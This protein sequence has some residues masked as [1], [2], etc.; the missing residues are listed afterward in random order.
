MKRIAF[1]FALTLLSG[2]PALAASVGGQ[3]PADTAI[4]HPRGY[5]ALNHSILIQ[6]GVI[7][8][9]DLFQGTGEYAE[10][11]V[12]YAPRPGS[13]AVFDARW[14]KRVAAAFKLN[15]QPGSAA[16]R[17][18]VER[19]SQV[20][21][22]SEIEALLF[23]RLVAEGGDASSRA[24]LANRS[25][26]LHLPV[27]EDYLLGVDQINLDASTGRF[28][29]VLAWGNAKDERRRVSGRLERMTEVPVLAKRKMG[30]DTIEEGDL[31]W[32]EMPQARLARNAV[33]DPSHLIGMAAK[34]TISAGNPITE[35]DIRRPVDIAK[36]A[37][38]TMVLST[39][40]MRLTAKGKALESGATGD[41]IR[42]S[43]SQTS[44]VIEGVVT[45]PGQVRVD[46]QV[47]LAMR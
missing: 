6:D 20:I 39:P 47:N 3:K 19:D 21:S 23:E 18:V 45:G 36:G 46:A 31:E 9:G 26:R 7:R 30:G 12:A 44:T 11:V 24:T 28:S 2:A 15:W 32:V 41:T 40:S 37:T 29:A 1:L 42:I 10:R 43:N 5:V 8:L 27:G 14:L 34:R 13:R 35:N 4:E 33:T 16:D 17:V 38:V 25:F 22:K